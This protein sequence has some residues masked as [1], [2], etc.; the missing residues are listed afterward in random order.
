MELLGG[1][2]HVEP[3]F[4]PLEIV[5]LLVQD[6][7]IVCSKRTVASEIILHALDGTPR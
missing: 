1:V 4:S 5:L 3:H 7:F 2:G 6:R